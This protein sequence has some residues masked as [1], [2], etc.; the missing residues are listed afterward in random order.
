M[1][2]VIYYNGY[3]EDFAMLTENF[4]MVENGGN[5][6]GNRFKFSNNTI[7]ILTLN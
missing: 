1:C 5:N 2:Q 4:A 6:I 7:N 3:H